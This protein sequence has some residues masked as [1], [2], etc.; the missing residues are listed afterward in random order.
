MITLNV[1]AL[2]AVS[3]RF[4]SFN[5]KPVKLSSSDPTEECN[6]KGYHNNLK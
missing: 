3:S 4:V 2:S 5:I 1:F 6:L